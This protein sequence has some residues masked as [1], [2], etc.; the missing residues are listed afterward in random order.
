MLTLPAHWPDVLTGPGAAALAE[1]VLPEFLPRQRWYADKAAPPSAVVL[2]DRVHL[3]SAAGDCVI[4]LVE[5]ARAG[6]PSQRYALPLA[7]AWEGETDAP[8]AR[9]EPH[10][11][12]R[13]RRGAKLGVLYDAT[14]SEH[15]ARIIIDAI[16]A[17]RQVPT[18][19][20]AVLS[21]RPTAAF[22]AFSDV[23]GES[24]R[25]LGVEQ[26]NASLLVDDQAVIKLYRRLQSGIHPEVEVGRFLTEIAGYANAPRLLGAVELAGADGEV[27]AVALLQ[28]FIHNQG[29]GWTLT[30]AHLERV[31]NE[32][33]LRV[34]TADATCDADAVHAGY[35]L[36]VGTLARRIG[37]LHQAFAIDIADPAFAPE[38][39]TAADVAAWNQQMGERAA[40]AHE[41]LS[42]AI[43]AEGMRDDAR[44]AARRL[45]DNWRTVE[46]RCTLPT[47]ALAG[48]AKTRIHGDLHLGQVVAAG[49]DFYILDFEGE[50]LHSLA[51]R[52]AK[53][54]PLR[55][56]AGMIRS[57]DY[58]GNAALMRRGT[59]APGGD[60]DLARRHAVVRWCTRTTARF[61]AAYREAAHGCPSL[62]MAETD[63]SIALDS[64]ILEKALYEVCYEAAHRPDWLLIP[65]AGISWIIEGGRLSGKSD[66]LS[67]PPPERASA[68]GRSAPPPLDHRHPRPRT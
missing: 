13:V 14:A 11:L 35:W 15:L 19:A 60:N 25:Y 4:V 8:L 43:S 2:A 65:L 38:V 45:L 50:P 58:A 61:I 67:A 1:R 20:N 53:S 31:L 37:A 9:L 44:A 7:I 29:D 62:P 42:R 26:S 32:F 49:T 33:D 51:H 24:C 56:I 5:V 39:I 57:F 16:R 28:E 41:T 55:D 21:C 10:V 27:T 34:P 17:E 63:F 66:R 47:A 48:T 59:P 52:R 68:N 64:F 30:L 36:Q 40:R 46:R 18:A 54:S 6:I 22:A 12:A 3:D 23:A